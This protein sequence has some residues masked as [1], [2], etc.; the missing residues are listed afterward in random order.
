MN[1]DGCKSGN[2]FNLCLICARHFWV[3]SNSVPQREG[4]QDIS[5]HS[6]AVAI[7]NNLGADRNASNGFQWKF[8]IKNRV[9]KA[10]RLMQASVCLFTEQTFLEVEKL[11]PKLFCVRK[12]K[13]PSSANFSLFHVPEIGKSRNI[14]IIGS[15]TVSGEPFRSCSSFGYIFAGC[16]HS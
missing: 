3:S 11:R 2:K 1:V 15:N 16:R 9:S 4:L 13:L 14:N 5:L 8:E 10:A 12:Q 7:N 6:L